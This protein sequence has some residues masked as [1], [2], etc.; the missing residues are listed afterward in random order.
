MVKKNIHVS[1]AKG[2]TWRVTQEGKAVSAHRTQQNAI[3]AAR[4]EA[5]KSGVELIT[6]SRDGKIRSKDSYVVAYRVIKESAGT[7]SVSRTK[8]ATAAR[9]VIRGGSD[10]KRRIS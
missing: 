8:I 2:R 7:P 1:A 9:S 3:D 10:S 6:H 4:R 5:K